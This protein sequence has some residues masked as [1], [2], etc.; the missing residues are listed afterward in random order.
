MAEVFS[1]SSSHA[2][3]RGCWIFARQRAGVCR[4]AFAVDKD[5]PKTE[6]FAKSFRETFKEARLPMPPWPTTAYACWSTPCAGPQTVERLPEELRQTK[7]FPGLTGLVSFAADQQMRR[8]VFVGTV[9]NSAFS[10][11]NRYDSRK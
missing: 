9:A 11:V 5:L 3:W 8:P 1:R 7:D 2:L 6:A 10:A 4:R